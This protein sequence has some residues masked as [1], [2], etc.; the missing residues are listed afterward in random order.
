MVLL[1]FH[2]PRTEAVKVNPKEVYWSVVSFDHAFITNA[3]ETKFKCNV[4]RQIMNSGG[5][6]VCHVFWMASRVGNNSTEFQIR[7][8]FNL[9]FSWHEV[10][11]RGEALILICGR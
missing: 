11:P 6:A 2:Q 3:F 8:M 4:V 5:D 9:V 1:F 7:K 10:Y